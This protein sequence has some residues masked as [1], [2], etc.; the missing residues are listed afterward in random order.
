MLCCTRAHL[1]Y[2]HTCLC[3]AHTSHYS[4]AYWPLVV[5][6]IFSTAQFVTLNCKTESWQRVQLEQGTSCG[7]RWRPNQVSEYWWTEIWLT[8]NGDMTFKVKQLFAIALSSLEA[9]DVVSASLFEC[10]LPSSGQTLIY[11]VWSY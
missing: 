4:V 5:H 3:K 11:T 6:S 1:Q 9:I 8:I 7:G 2:L 10:F